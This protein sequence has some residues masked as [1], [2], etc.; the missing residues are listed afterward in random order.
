MTVSWWLYPGNLF[1][2]CSMYFIFHTS[3]SESYLFSYSERSRPF[4]DQPAFGTLA[5][6]KMLRFQ[7]SLQ[8][9]LISTFTSLAFWQEFWS[10]RILNRLSMDNA[11]LSLNAP[12][13]SSMKSTTK[14][15]RFLIDHRRSTVIL[16]RWIGIDRRYR[17]YSPVGESLST[18]DIDCDR[19][20][21]SI[22]RWIGI[23]I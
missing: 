21:G 11:V 7:N 14:L 15:S 20:T 12:Q 23:D 19:S 1:C 13:V 22:N 9:A 3:R 5:D 17:P 6:S 8:F 10:Q 4:C 16:R 2:S 18:V